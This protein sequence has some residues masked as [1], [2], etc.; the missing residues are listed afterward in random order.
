MLDQ[1][2]DHDEFAFFRFQALCIV[3]YMALPLAWIDIMQVVT[4]SKSV[5]P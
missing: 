5:F 2:T 3:F 4:K 1:G